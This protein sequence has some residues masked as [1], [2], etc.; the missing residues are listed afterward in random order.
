LRSAVIALAITM[1]ALAISAT[2]ASATTTRAEWIAQVD[3]I[4]QI[5]LEGKNAAFKTSRGIHTTIN[6]KPK[7]GIQLFLKAISA[8]LDA[9]QQVGDF[10]FT[11][12]LKVTVV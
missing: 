1:I 9:N 12:C 2:P 6:G 10:G 4:C 11:S 5:A 3:P 8:L 7:R